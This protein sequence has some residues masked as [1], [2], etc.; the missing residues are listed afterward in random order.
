MGRV[1]WRFCFVE[2]A[3]AAKYGEINAPNVIRF[4]VFD[5]DNPASVTYAI[6]EGRANVMNARDVVPAELLESVNELHGKMMSGGLE[7][8]MDATPCD[9]RCGSRRLGANFRGH[10]RGDVSRR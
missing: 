10:P 1:C 2:D 4:L 7:A 3:F 6:R 8:F 9:L 5:R